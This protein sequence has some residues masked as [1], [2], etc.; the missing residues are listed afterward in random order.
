[1]ILTQAPLLRI[2]LIRQE[3][4]HYILVIDMHHIITDGVSMGILVK[5]VMSAYAGEELPPLNHQYKDYSE[6]QHRQRGSRARKR[7]GSL[8]VKGICRRDSP[9]KPAH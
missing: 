2:G 9:V 8:L 4:K 6:W 1:L 3:E 7:T 5:E